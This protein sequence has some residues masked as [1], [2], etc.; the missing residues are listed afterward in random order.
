MAGELLK[1]REVLRKG[2]KVEFYL[3]DEGDRYQSYIISVSERELQVASPVDQSGA[4]LALNPQMTFK[5]LV[6]VKS[7]EYQFAVTFLKQETR[8][9]V[10][11][12]HTSLPENVEHSQNRDFVRVRVDLPLEVRLIGA[13]GSIGRQQRVPMLDMSG[14]GLSFE[15]GEAVETGLQVALEI[16]SIP[17][18]GTLSVLSRVRQCKVQNPKAV[19]PKYH[20]G[21]S[22]VKLPRPVVNRLVKYLF[23]VQR[24]RINKASW[25]RK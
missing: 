10:S 12:W 21:V 23:T 11:L 22:F 7:S 18:I 5:A 9:R 17:E 19:Y 13:D 1:A 8:G 4:A 24:Q 20:V 2:Q 25:L 14:S 3:E 16:N 15:L 6:R